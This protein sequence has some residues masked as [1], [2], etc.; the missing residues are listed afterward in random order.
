MPH[1]FEVGD[2]DGVLKTV[3]KQRVHEGGCVA[4]GAGEAEQRPGQVPRKEKRSQV[5]R[6]PVAHQ[7][8]HA[9]NRRQV[10]GADGE[11]VLP[12]ALHPQSGWV[13]VE[14]TFALQHP[15]VVV[16]HFK[17]WSKISLFFYIT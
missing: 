15:R 14:R 1:S 6:L 16:G 2:T 4:E 13:I 5:Q 3:R 9:E 10:E 7:P 8:L 12:A 17:N 11:A